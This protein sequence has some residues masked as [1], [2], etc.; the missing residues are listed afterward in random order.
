M[1]LKYFFF[2]QTSSYLCVIGIL[3]FNSIYLLYQ[4]AETIYV[5]FLFERFQHVRSV[6]MFL[7]HGYGRMRLFRIIRSLLRYTVYSYRDN[8]Q[9]R[10]IYISLIL[11]ENIK[12]IK[13]RV[14]ACHK[15]F[16]IRIVCQIF[17]GVQ[18][19]I[20]YMRRLREQLIRSFF[21]TIRFRVHSWI[22]RYVSVNSIRKIIQRFQRRR[23]S[24]DISYVYNV[25]TRLPLSRSPP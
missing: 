21:I 9:I 11:L 4:I 7:D 18:R 12:L 14:R 19:R 16:S 20:E 1:Y 15:Y 3:I 23:I 17:I 24:S 6:G 22:S 2:I 25:R 8:L 13:D 10:K 5:E